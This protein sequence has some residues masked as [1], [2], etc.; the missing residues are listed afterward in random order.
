VS[1]NQVIISAAPT[2]HIELANLIGTHH[3]AVRELN[4]LKK[5]NYVQR[6]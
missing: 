2:H 1:G 4:E 6:P 3:E 5:H